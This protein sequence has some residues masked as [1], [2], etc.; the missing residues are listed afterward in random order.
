M[1]NFDKLHPFE[2]YASYSVSLKT[3]KLLLLL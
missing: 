2:A 3:K 1:Q